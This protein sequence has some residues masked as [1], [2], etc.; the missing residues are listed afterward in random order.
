MFVGNE[1]KK[2]TTL[3]PTFDTMNVEL[4]D[5]TKDKMG[6]GQHGNPFNHK[7]KMRDLSCLAFFY[8][9]LV[10][11]FIFCGVAYINGDPKLL[12]FGLDYRGRV[13]DEN[14][15]AGFEARYWVN[16]GQ[17][18]TA[19]LSNPLNFYD[20]KSVCLK[21]CPHVSKETTKNYTE[22]QWVCNYP[23][24]YGPSKQFPDPTQ[25]GA[26]PPVPMTY[27]EWY[28]RKY[29]YFDVLTN[30]QKQSSLKLKGPCYPVLMKTANQYGV[31][32]PYDGIV[33]HD[34]VTLLY[35]VWKDMGGIDVDDPD[36][37]IENSVYDYIGDGVRVMGRYMNDLTNAWV[38][39]LASG[40][41]VTLVLSYF[42][43]FLLKIFAPLMAWLVILTANAFS[44]I[45]TIL[46]YMK[47]GIFSADQIDAFVGTNYSD[48]LPDTFDSSKAN[49]DTL[50]ICAVV[51]TIFT[52][53]LMAF[54][55][56][57]ISRVRVALRC[58][59]VG[60]KALSKAPQAMFY[61]ATVP[62]LY[63]VGFIALWLFASVHVFSMGDVEQRSCSI[64]SNEAQFM[65]LGSNP[66][67]GPRES[68]QCG[69]ETSVNNSMKYMGLY[70]LFGLCWSL[71]F[72]TGFTKLVVAGAI[73][74]YYWER[75]EYHI[76]PLFGSFKRA[77]KYHQGS[78][79]F[80]SFLVA[81]IQFV[82]ILLKILE[83]RMHA[84]QNNSAVRYIWY[85]I[86][87]C[88]SCLRSVIT[89]ISGQAYVMI[90][91]EGKGFISSAMR[92]GGLIASNALKS[93]AVQIVGDSIL[94][95]AK[96][97]VVA[98]A[99]VASIAMLENQEYYHG[100]LKVTSPLTPCCASMI[101]SY[102]LANKFFSVM[103]TSIDTIFLS[104]CLDCEKNNGTPLFAPPAL[105][106]VMNDE[107]ED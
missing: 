30:E 92:A 51:A 17:I 31:C 71:A 45:L 82:S 62:F 87:C 106:A 25:T 78:I 27:N 4:E 42:W 29:N 32:Q 99:G 10:V 1:G 88:I 35:K 100:N 50:L 61:P 19:V 18:V 38:V 21:Q 20:A 36:S 63:S 85:C 39:V 74:P 80:G 96:L 81:L 83:K 48:D 24:G 28:V 37:V 23:D 26:A 72:N 64:D 53:F 98:G 60:R 16:P 49:K 69:Y 95:L 76:A 2:T 11:F 56:F 47:A 33:G 70:F 13:C 40:V 41:G 101:V 79:A 59:E 52:A 107:D 66:N 73:A 97:S 34:D 3:N 93:A 91:I 9:F 68:C 86:N 84:V 22:L 46:L 12:F 90:A 54:T 77:F 55:L 89:F 8:A 102:L 104:Y 5:K 6:E 44:I 103:E 14:E 57:M 15:L 7:N 67:C 43:L 65:G 75:G 105:Q 58:L 94:A